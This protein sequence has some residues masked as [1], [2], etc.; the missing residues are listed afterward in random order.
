MRLFNRLLLQKLKAIKNGPMIVTGDFNVAY[1]KLDLARP[2][3]NQQST[4]F[5]VL[6]RQC[7][8]ELQNLGFAD[9]FRSLHSEGGQYIWWPYS[10][11][12]RE[13][14]IGWRIDYIFVSKDILPRLQ[15]AF[16]LKEVAGSDH[17]PVGIDIDMEL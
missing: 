3:D 13:R 11:D 1:S 4:M 7:L 15:N 14:N 6:E 2:E 12:A 9:T 5:T 17:S 16:I 8:G 10:P